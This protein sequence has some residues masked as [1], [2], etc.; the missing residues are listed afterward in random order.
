MVEYAEF[1]DL[2]ASQIDEPLAADDLKYYFKKFDQNGDGFIT[3]DEL[4]LVMKTFGGKTYSKEEIDDAIKTAD[5]NADG[6]VSYEGTLLLWRNSVGSKR[7]RLH[8]HFL[9][10]ACQTTSIS[11]RISN[12]ALVT[13]LTLGGKI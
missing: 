4:A 9:R 13:S 7:L 2:M 8:E 1:E 12:Y 11:A 10:E 3:G 5:I 6:K